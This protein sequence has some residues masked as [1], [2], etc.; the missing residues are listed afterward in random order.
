[1]KRG[2]D[3]RLT[4]ERAREIAGRGQ[5]S[6]FLPSRIFC[7]QARQIAAVKIESQTRSSRSSEIAIVL[8]VPS[9][10]TPLSSSFLKAAKSLRRAKYGTLAA[11][12][13]GRILATR[14]PF[15]VTRISPCRE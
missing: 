14:R 4:V 11:G 10:V 13:A 2:D 15:S 3:L 12:A 8:S 9:P 1:M 7:E 6:N 5:R